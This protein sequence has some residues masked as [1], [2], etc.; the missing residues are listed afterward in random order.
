MKRFNI[1]QLARQIKLP[2]RTVYSYVVGEKCPRRPKARLLENTT[3]VSASIWLKGDPAEIQAALESSPMVEA[4]AARRKL[5]NIFKS[6]IEHLS[7][8]DAA[9]ENFNQAL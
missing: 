1:A 5:A 8:D 9:V 3:G 4:W 2:Y 7:L 6:S